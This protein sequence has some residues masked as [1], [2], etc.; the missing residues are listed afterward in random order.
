M[1]ANAYA[2]TSIIIAVGLF[3]PLAAPGEETSL[4]EAKT[5][6]ELLADIESGNL[7]GFMVILSEQADLSSVEKIR[8]KR[9]KGRFVFEKLRETA[10]RTQPPVIAELVSRGFR[11]TPYFISNEIAV[12]TSK[13]EF[14]RRKRLY[15]CSQSAPMWQESSI[16]ENHF[17]R[18]SDSRCRKLKRTAG[19]VEYQ[20][21]WRNETS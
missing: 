17:R 6:P 9:D 10:S 8:G 21:D 11:V 16:Q 19:R 20:G 7:S 12:K 4:V 18:R 1:K 13:G 15:R 5:Q 2:W 3:S 14:C